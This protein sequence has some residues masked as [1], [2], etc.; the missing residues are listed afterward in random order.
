MLSSSYVDFYIVSTSDCLLVNSLLYSCFLTRSTLKKFFFHASKEMARQ[1]LTTRT[2]D[3]WSNEKLDAVDWE[4]LDMALK[5]KPDMY[6]IWRSKQNSGFLGTRV[7][8]G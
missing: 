8:V 6:K 5:N 7:Q 4:N 1:H 2:K 3:K